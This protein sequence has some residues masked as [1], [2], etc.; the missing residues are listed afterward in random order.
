M[1]TMRE[2]LLH[3]KSMNG[4]RQ[5]GKRK[6]SLGRFQLAGKIALVI[7]GEP[8]NRPGHCPGSGR[9]RLRCGAG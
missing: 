1:T 7:G 3:G 2:F 6:S 4:E 8:G 5:A 9:S